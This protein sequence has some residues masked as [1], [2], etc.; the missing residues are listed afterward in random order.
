MNKEKKVSNDK[1][2]SLKKNPDSGKSS[3][4][5]KDDKENVYEE[6]KI[7][8]N[9]NI[10]QIYQRDLMSSQHRRFG[11][12]DYVI[13]NNSM[14]FQLPTNNLEA[15][16]PGVELIGGDKPLKGPKYNENPYFEWEEEVSGEFDNS[17]SESEI[18]K[19]QNIEEDNINTK[20]VYENPEMHQYL[21]Y[22]NDIEDKYS[23]SSKGDLESKSSNIDHPKELKDKILDKPFVPKIQNLDNG[24]NCKLI[25]YKLV[26]II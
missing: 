8:D 15:V 18:H 23:I 22:N 17:I 11:S 7:D 25:F 2:A 4:F 13:R 5:G 19:N 9:Y 21:K 3:A 26:K 24:K 20:K 6:E 1:L 14:M 16:K 10:E 12:P